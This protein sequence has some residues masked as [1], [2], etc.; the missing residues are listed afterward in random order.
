M[1][2]FP[3]DSSRTP[4]APVVGGSLGRLNACAS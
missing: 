2:G 1:A 4:A 3:P